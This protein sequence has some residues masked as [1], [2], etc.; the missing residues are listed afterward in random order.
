MNAP[1]A[2]MDG[3]TVPKA[4]ALGMSPEEYLE[5]NDSYH[6]FQKVSGLFVTGPTGTNGMDIQITFLNS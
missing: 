3:E 2:I 6:F 4:R 5:N 1:G